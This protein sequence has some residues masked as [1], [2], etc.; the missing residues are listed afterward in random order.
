[1]ILKIILFKVFFKLLVKTMIRNQDENDEKIKM[2]I[3]RQPGVSFTQLVTQI[4]LAASTLRHRLMTLELAGEIT[5][6]KQ[7]NQNQYFPITVLSQRI[8]GKGKMKA[9][10]SQFAAQTQTEH[11]NTSDCNRGGRH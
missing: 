1:M 6:K 11:K 4:G 10:E 7:R 9:A 5:C 3:L 2:S 8:K